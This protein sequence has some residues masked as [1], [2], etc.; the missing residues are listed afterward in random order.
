MPPAEGLPVLC[1]PGPKTLG[2]PT[3]VRHDRRVHPTV[4]QR[5]QA[6]LHELTAVLAHDLRAPTTIVD[7]YADLL[8]QSWDTLGEQDRL[9]YVRRIKGAA[10]TL[11]AVLE[12][13]LT[14]ATLDSGR[15]VSRPTVVALR[16]VVEV[17][18]HVLQGHCTVDTSGV[19]D[20][21]AWIDPTHLRQVLDNLLTN[22]R[23]Y[24]GPH[25][26]VSTRPGPRS[27]LLSVRDDGPGVDR[28][29]VPRLFER[30]STSG[31]ARRGESRGTGLGLF[32]A[33][34]LL[35]LDEAD[36]GFAPVP[37][38]GAEFVLELAT[39]A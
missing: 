39:P 2:A 8:L 7:G 12:N 33:R 25:V 22:A 14:A 24:G 28:Q 37:G 17:S 18:A 5:R 34:E 16:P 29:L 23:R 11:Q 36:I 27:V 3:P 38:G 1:C 10:A 6:A 31:S 26:V 32:I 20:E 4:D 19:G 21:V 13:S 9:D 30:Y 35:R 15:L